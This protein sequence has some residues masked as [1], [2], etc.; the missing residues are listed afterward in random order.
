MEDLAYIIAAQKGNQ[1]AFSF[2]MDKY[3]D[4]VYGFQIKRLQN[5]IE[6]EDIS[7][8]TFA[9]AFDK[10]HLFETKYTFSTWLISIS[11]N[12]QIDNLRKSSNRLTSPS[13]TNPQK[14][15]N[16]IDE[17]PTAE[18]Q[19]IIEQNLSYLLSCIRKLNSPYRE[20][21][22]FRFLQEKSYK[23]ISELTEMSLSN[24]KITLLRAKKLLANIIQPN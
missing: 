2:L 21:I 19:I 10:I 3:W 22:Q 20:M 4:Y 12:I 11:K 14:L 24:V 23:E 8:E 6:A 17:S 16:I 9:K 18:D 13:D 5:Q 15:K 7:I 1:R